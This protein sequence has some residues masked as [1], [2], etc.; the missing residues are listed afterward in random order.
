MFIL[1]HLVNPVSLIARAKL[2]Q[3]V[4]SYFQHI[5]PAVFG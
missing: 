1:K 3:H 2:E 4:A 5:V